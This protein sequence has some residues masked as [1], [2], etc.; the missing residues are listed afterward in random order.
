[1]QRGQIFKKQM[2]H[3]G[4]LEKLKAAKQT[5]TGSTAPLAPDLQ[6]LPNILQTKEDDLV[7]AT[8]QRPLAENDA[9]KSGQ[10]AQD[11]VP[12]SHA[13]GSAVKIENQMSPLKPRPQG[14]EAE[15]ADQSGF[16]KAVG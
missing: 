13:A 3:E 8:G 1:M 15:A 2:K 11:S 14:A 16:P 12:G 7:V 5:G 4:S 10:E 9:L 6:A